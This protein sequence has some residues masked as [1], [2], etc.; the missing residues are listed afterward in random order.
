VSELAFLSP[1][2]AEARSGFEPVLRSRALGTRGAELGIEDVSLTTGKIEIRGP[3]ND[4]EIDGADVFK[5]TPERALVLCPYEGA[6]E[7]RAGMGHHFRT[8]TDV[9]GA[10]AGLR[11]ERPDAARLMR[12]L[13]E[14][15]LES[16]PAVGA[17]AHVQAFVLRDNESAFRLFFP[18][19][20]AD[21]VGDVVLDAAEG[22]E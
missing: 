10:L 1:D 15:D 21:Y 3:V 19:E 16:L 13:T 12:R 11:I 6:A 2:R 22:L 7:I 8:V 4:L 9:T 14:L 5:V 17:V 18:Q 20:Y